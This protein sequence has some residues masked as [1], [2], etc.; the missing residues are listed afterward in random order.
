MYQLVPLPLWQHLARG[1]YRRKDLFCL[2]AHHVGGGMED[3]STMVCGREPDRTEA[4][5]GY[6][7]WPLSPAGLHISKVLQHLQ[8]VL[9]VGGYHT[10]TCGVH[11]TGE[12]SRKSPQLPQFDAECFPNAMC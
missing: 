4:D 7:S 11:F 9:L 3:N 1:T 8:K 12:S 5:K 6:P 10:W 2:S